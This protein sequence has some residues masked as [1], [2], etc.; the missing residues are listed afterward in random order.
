V[1]FHY[2]LIAEV[3]G[4]PRAVQMALAAHMRLLVEFGPKLGRPSADTLKGSR[5][6]NL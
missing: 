6:A 4:L 5:I 3:D 2:D 1:E